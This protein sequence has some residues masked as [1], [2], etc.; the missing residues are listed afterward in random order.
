MTRVGVIGYGVVG[1]ATA[2]VLRRLGHEVAIWDADC[3]RLAQGREEG[4][5]FLCWDPSPDI[6]FLCVPEND[7]RS[8]L[9]TA[10]DCAIVVIRS[11]VPPGT[12]DRLSKEFARP[13]AFIPETLRE[14]SALWDALSPAFILIGSHSDEQARA[15]AELFAPLLA[16][17]TIVP[18][19]TAEMVKLSLN[20]Y[21]HTQ[22]S[23]WN[24][25][26]G[27]CAQVGIP[28]HVVGKLCSQDP[29]VSAYGAVMHGR[30][31]G[32]RC[33]PKDL[34]QFVAFARELKYEPELLATVQRQNDVLSARESGLRDWCNDSASAIDPVL[35]WDVLEMGQAVLPASIR[36]SACLEEDAGWPVASHWQTPASKPE[37]AAS[38]V[39]AGQGFSPPRQPNGHVALTVEPRRGARGEGSSHHTMR[40]RRRRIALYSHDTMGLGHKRRNMLIAQ[41]LAGS[42]LRAD[43]LLIIGD[44]EATSTSAFPSG[45]DCLSLP[46]LRKEENGRYRSR[47]LEL[48]LEETVRLRAR[49]IN[50]ALESFSPDVLI[51]DKEP[52]GALREL[53]PALEHL[54]ARKQTRCVLGLREVLDDPETVSR[55]WRRTKSQAAIRRYYDA[56]W[57]YGDP[58][59]FDP[60]KE[61]RFPPDLAEKVRYT[62]YLDQRMRILYAARDGVP[63]SAPKELPPHPF[64]LCLLGGGQ[65]GAQLAGAF[66]RAE[67]PADTHGL[68]LTG[69]FLPREAQ[70]NLRQLAGC[71]SRLHVFG[72]VDEPAPLLERADRVVAMGGYNTIAEV[73][74]FEKRALIVPRVKP[75]REQLIRAE[76]LRD[77]GMVEVLHPDELS[78]SA[79][80]AWLAG[81]SE[82]PRA[83]ERIDINGLGRIPSLLAELLSVHPSAGRA[84]ASTQRVRYAS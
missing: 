41:A 33:L 56:I 27:I 45:V 28:S 36:G 50:A 11:T 30:A 14:A 47:S 70:A 42:Q 59:V 73:L 52:R 21:L 23:F 61:Y 44:V 71:N 10:P 1:K 76:R 29:R 34:A 81:D 43:V 54:R 72:F 4:Y 3:E 20:A 79:L 37:S 7:L 40:S 19:C 18:P 57:V 67:L 26:H 84:P 77:L 62:G 49:V 64:A 68:I 2:E 22:V 15:L 83:H 46:A 16:P 8:A 69:P 58:T 55:E 78:P 38:G 17:I 63:L 32:G 75:R 25:V 80:T 35:R 53:D 12:T 39:P 65:D 5:S 9:E 6:L 82:P 66:A 48:S 13:L 24:E 51:V 60:I 74:S 31:V